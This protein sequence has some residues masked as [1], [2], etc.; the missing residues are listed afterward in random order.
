MKNLYTAASRHGVKDHAKV[1]N[2][3]AEILDE[4]TTEAAAK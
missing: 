3:M 4:I 1:V 2:K